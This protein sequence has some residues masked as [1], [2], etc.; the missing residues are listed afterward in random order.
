MQWIWGECINR[1]ISD[2]VNEIDED[3]LTEEEYAYQHQ[4]AEDQE[5]IFF[6]FGEDP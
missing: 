1:I 3:R 5:S 4:E 2:S 6:N